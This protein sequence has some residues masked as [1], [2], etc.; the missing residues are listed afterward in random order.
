[1]K[2]AIIL[3]GMPDK[4]EYLAMGSPT[5]QHWYG[6]LQ[7]QLQAKGILTEL[8][9]MPIPYEPWLSENKIKVGKL[10]L[11]APW[12]DP[13]HESQN[14]VTD[15]FNFEIDPELSSRTNSITVFYSTDDSA[16]IVNTVEVLEK[17]VKDIHVIKLDHKG[18]FT[19]ED[20]GT[21]EFPELLKEAKAN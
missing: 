19:L 10:L 17:S 6:W 14:L 11:V 21:E 15:F 9:A 2:N 16:D 7:R 12:I 1:M 13:D 20:M 4:E 5:T 8:P 3:H 18:H